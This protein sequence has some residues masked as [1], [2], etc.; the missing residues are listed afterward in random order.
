[1]DVTLGGGVVGPPTP[2]TPGVVGCEVAFEVTGADVVPA[3]VPNRPKPKVRA[4]LPGNPID[5]V[6]PLD[7]SAIVLCLTQWVLT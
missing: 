5:L 7:L 3:W 4:V 6:S 1:M 2:V